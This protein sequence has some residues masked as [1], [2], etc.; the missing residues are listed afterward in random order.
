[1][2]LATFSMLSAGTVEYFRQQTNSTYIN[3][4]NHDVNI[5]ARDMDVLYQ[6]PQY[7]LMGISEIFVLIT[8]LLQLNKINIYFSVVIIA[9]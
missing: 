1:M 3:Y 8:G 9:N 4:V 6:I 2:L 5:T 7:T